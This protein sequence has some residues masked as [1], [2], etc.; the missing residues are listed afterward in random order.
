MKEGGIAGILGVPGLTGVDSCM[1]KLPANP[2]SPEASQKGPTCLKVFSTAP[3]KSQTSKAL[4]GVYLDAPFFKAA[5]PLDLQNAFKAG[6][7]GRYLVCFSPSK[8]VG[9]QVP[10]PA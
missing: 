4:C 8:A 9:A 6:F 3:S 2:T 1:V 7:G 5:N 10:T